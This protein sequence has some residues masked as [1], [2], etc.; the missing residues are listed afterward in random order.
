MALSEDQIKLLQSLDGWEQ[1]FKETPS[2]N[3]SDQVK[4]GQTIHSLTYS[5]SEGVRNLSIVPDLLKKV[6]R[7]ELWKGFIVESNDQKAS[8]E[9]FQKFVMAPIP[10]G[11]GTTIEDIKR[12][13][14]H[15]NDVLDLID[16]ALRRPV[17]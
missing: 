14:S 6:L 17:G 9:N 13:C 1:Y 11:M 8:F 7:G 5:Y 10:E 2:E 15:R 12:I 16:E 4:K 3:F